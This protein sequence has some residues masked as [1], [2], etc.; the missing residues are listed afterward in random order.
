MRRSP[1]YLTFRDG[2]QVQTLTGPT[3]FRDTELLPATGYRYTGAAEWGS[4][5]SE[6]AEPLTVNTQAPPLAAARLV[7]SMAIRT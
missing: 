1:E 3:R 6:T 2:D 7:G 4:R 5:T